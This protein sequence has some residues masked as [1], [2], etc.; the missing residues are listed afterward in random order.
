M[1]IVE[2]ICEG[3]VDGVVVGFAVG[4]ID[5]KWVG[6]VDGICNVAVV[7]ACGR[8]FNMEFSSLTEVFTPSRIMLLAA[9]P[10]AALSRVSSVLSCFCTELLKDD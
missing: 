5:G 4:N 7:D 2:G 9:S 1:D 8:L 10:I 6:D 3:I